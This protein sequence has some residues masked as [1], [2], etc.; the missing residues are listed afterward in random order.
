MRSFPKVSS[1]AFNFKPTDKLSGFTLLRSENVYLMDDV[2]S[3]DDQE[4]QSR[5]N[6]WDDPIRL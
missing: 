1:S 2:K 4:T 6:Q 5:S 3:F